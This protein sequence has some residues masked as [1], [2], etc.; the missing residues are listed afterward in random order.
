MGN[1]PNKQT[2]DRQNEP[3]MQTKQKC[4][5]AASKCKTV[6]WLIDALTYYQS[7]DINNN[8]QDQEDMIKHFELRYKTFLNDFIHILTRHDEEINDIYNMIMSKPEMVKCDLSNCPSAIRRHSEKSDD[9]KENENIL[10]KNIIF[11]RDTMDS[12]HCFIYHLYDLGLRI[13]I[14]DIQYDIKSDDDDEPDFDLHFTKIRQ[15]TKEVKKKLSELGNFDFKRVE[16]AKFNLK[17]N[18]QKEKGIITDCICSCR[19][20]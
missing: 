11:W 3:V 6:H 18:Q 5:S 20:I 16:S 15:I 9:T 17:N 1:K 19:N 13:N 2:V 8:E 4:S 7:L 10:D 14:D 12:C